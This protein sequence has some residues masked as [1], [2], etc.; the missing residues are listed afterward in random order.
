[1]VKWIAGAR[2]DIKM[3]VIAQS[4]SQSMPVRGLCCG[5]TRE[6]AYSGNEIGDRIENF[7]KGKHFFDFLLYV[8]ANC[9]FE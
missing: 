1:M 4:R 7:R 9:R 2:F 5:M 6:Q 3:M 8:F